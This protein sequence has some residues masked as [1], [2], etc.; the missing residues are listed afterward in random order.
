[1]K[2]FFRWEFGVRSEQ[3][4]KA[5]LTILSLS[6]VLMS[7]S[8]TM[9]IPFLPMYLIEELSVAQEDVNLWSGVVFSASFLISGVMAPVWGAIADKHSRKMMAVR[10]AVLLAVS[11]GMGGLVQDVWQLLFMRCFQGFSAGL[12]PACLAIMSSSAP[13]DRLGFCMGVM[14]GAMTA[15]GV[16]GPFIGGSLA[17]VFGMRMTFFLGSAALFLITFLLIFFIHEPP[18]KASEARQA[19]GPKTNLLKVPVVQRLL[20]CAGVVQMTILLQQPVMPLYVAELQGSMERIVFVTGLLFSIVGISGVI[21]SP[22]WGVL[23]QRVGFR[24][25]LYAALFG[26]AVFGMIQAIPDTIVSFGVWR[27][28]G[29]LTFAGIFPSINAVLTRSTDPKERGRVFGLSYAAQQVGSVLG[30]IAGGGMAMAF[31]IKFVVFFSG[32]V[33]L[34]LAVYLYLKR[35]GE[36][37]ELSPAG[38]ERVLH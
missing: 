33:L 11:Y 38:E 9:L 35:P 28:I 15:G 1:M 26:T 13:R 5:T 21:A 14:Q 4:W 18:K 29:G 32:F 19:A 17:E 16:L 12:W 7:L 20:L 8:Y 36:G 6:C 30:P 24:P 22:V 25:A 37:E 3:S 27:F 2:P 31:G 10:A 34:P 23:G